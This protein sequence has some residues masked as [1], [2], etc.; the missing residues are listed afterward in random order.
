MIVYTDGG[1]RGNPGIAGAGVYITNM[2]NQE[3][4][5]EFKYLDIKTNNEAEY[6]ALNLAI[7]YL[8]Q[9]IKVPTEIIFKLDSKLVVEDIYTNWRNR[10]NDGKYNAMLTTNVGGGKASVGGTKG[11]VEKH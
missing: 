3:I 1:S 11:K 10:S 8:K 5:R 6:L 4:Y 9:T 7:N 2:D